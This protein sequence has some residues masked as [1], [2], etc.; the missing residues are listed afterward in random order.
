MATS[1]DGHYTRFDTSML[2]DA[3]F[4]DT[5][6]LNRALGNL[7]HLAD[8]C[9]QQRIGWV[10][11]LGKDPFVVDKTQTPGTTY[12]SSDGLLNELWRSA[13]FDLHV[14]ENNATYPCAVRVRIGSAHAVEQATITA[15]LVPWTRPAGSEIIE[16]GVNAAVG[17]HVG[18]AHAWQLLAPLIYL[19]SHMVNRA[20]WTV[21]SANS[22]GGADVGARWIRVQLVIAGMVSAATA[23]AELSGCSL[24]EYITP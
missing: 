14:R 21:S 7:D 1:D 19:D 16:N 2:D 12:F 5:G 22:V 3:D 15:A 9:A 8:Q 11:P 18:V 20:T 4:C 13:A 23:T 17:V 10:L 24:R 6:L